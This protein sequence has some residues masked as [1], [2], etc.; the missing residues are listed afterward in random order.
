MTNSI[1]NQIAAANATFVAPVVAAPVEVV[2]PGATTPA[3]DQA[4][5]PV[6]LTRAQTLQKT[7]DAENAKIEA[8]IKRRDLA[9]SQLNNIDKIESIKP[10]SLI[11][12]RL[13]RAETLRDVAGAVAGI[14][15]EENGD[16]KFKVLVGT[17]YDASVETV[18]EG[19]V[20]S[21]NS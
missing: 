16:K 6:P 13:G 15:V 17:G 12:V 1:E 5:A 21:V 8:A 20:V 11:T 18:N 10:G 19:Q 9:Q 7:I 3:P 4:P 14:K 2:V